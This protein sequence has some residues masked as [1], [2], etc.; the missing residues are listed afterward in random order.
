MQQAEK[1]HRA[2]PVLRVHGIRA[3]R[4]QI[5]APRKNSFP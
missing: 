4:N 3:I 2:E 5:A 1:R